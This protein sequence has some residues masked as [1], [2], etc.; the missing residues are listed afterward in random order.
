MIRAMQFTPGADYTFQIDPVD[1]NRGSAAYQGLVGVGSSGFYL[2]HDGFF[3]FNAGASTPIGTDKVD[4]WFSD[5]SSATSLS[6]TVAGIDPR[7]K[8]IFWSFIS[9]ENTDASLAVAV[10]DRML[11]YHWPSKRFAWAQIAVSAY[12]DISAAGTNLDALGNIDTLP[13]SLD[14]GAY[15][16]DGIVSN[17]AVFGTDFKMGYLSGATLESLFE[18]KRLEFF[19]PARQYVRGFWPIVDGNEVSISV[20]PTEALQDSESFGAYVSQ[21]TSG[22]IPADSSARMHSV[23]VKIA[24]SSTYKNARG[25]YV[26]AIPDGDL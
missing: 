23:R 22:F 4:K 8:L 10:P 24:S 12:A 5:T 18:V 9:N 1:Q 13:Y 14:S 2:A 19:P 11:I 16:S 3:Y 21:E 20:S 7:K 26:D 6:R 15:N 17:M 25:I